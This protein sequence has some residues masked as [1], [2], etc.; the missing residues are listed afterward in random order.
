MKTLNAFLVTMFLVVFVV[1]WVTPPLAAQQ[2]EWC[3]KL[4][5]PA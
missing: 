4:P 1:D 2:A 5:R 3:K